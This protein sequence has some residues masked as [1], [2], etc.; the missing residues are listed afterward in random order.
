MNYIA[1]KNNAFILINEMTNIQELIDQGFTI[2]TQE[3]YNEYVS[4]NS[5]LT[6]DQVLSLLESKS[7]DYIAFGESLWE[8]IK[9]KTWAINTYNKSIGND[10]GIEGMKTLLS[11]SDL[12][13]K[14]LRAGSLL[15]GRD[16]CTQLKTQLPQYTSVSEFAI[17]EINT[18]LEI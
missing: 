3:Q 14:S 5:Q 4:T 17:L 12:L 15:T 2:Y 18:F 10:L 11:I 16:I 1:I 13:E 7:Q 9:R 6:Q 8:Q